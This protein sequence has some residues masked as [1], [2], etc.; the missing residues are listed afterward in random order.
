MFWFVYRNF[1]D[2]RWLFYDWDEKNLRYCYD[3][4]EAKVRWDA[5]GKYQTSVVM[6]RPPNKEVVIKFPLAPDEKR[7]PAMVVH[8]WIRNTKM[9]T[10]LQTVLNQ[11]LD[12]YEISDEGV[13]R[14]REINED[15]TLSNMSRLQ[16]IRDVMEGIFRVNPVKVRASEDKNTGKV[17]YTERSDMINSI[18]DMSYY[19][20]WTEHKTNLYWVYTPAVREAIFPESNFNGHTLQWRQRDAMLNRGK[21]TCIV[22]PRAAGKSMLLT[23]FAGWYAMKDMITK[24]ERNRPFIIHYFGLSKEANN[25]V[26]AYI[27][28][29]MK[30]LIQ[31]DKVVN[32]QKSYN[33][34]TFYDGKHERVIQFKSQYE[35]GVGRGERPN[36]VILD[37]AARLSNEVYKT[38]IGTDEAAIYC[39]STIDYETK[40]NWF[41]DLFLECQKRQR[42]YIPIDQCIHK[43]W[44]KYDM[45]KVRTEEEFRNKV[46]EGVIDAMREDLFLERPMVGL[47]Y[48]IDDIETKTDRQKEEII[49]RAMQQGE[50]Y[51]LAEYYGEYAD[52][53]VE[54]NYEGLLENIMPKIYD[55]VVVWFDNGGIYDR[56]AIVAIGI[57]DWMAYIFASKQ[58]DNDKIKR[59]EQIKEEL[60]NFSRFSREKRVHLVADVSGNHDGAIQYLEEKIGYLDLGIYYTGWESAKKKGPI[61]HVV[62]KKHLVNL[63]KTEFFRKANVLISA[64][65][66]YDGWLLDELSRFKLKENKKYEAV[67]GKDDQVNAM[68]MALYYAYTERLQYEFMDTEKKV[69]FDRD[70]IVRNYYGDIEESKREKE[71]EQ[72]FATIYQDYRA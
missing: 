33:R 53:W 30:K 8:D 10:K 15:V 63:T 45:D 21:I 7:I 47:R 35:E 22:A 60:E 17:K 41:Y 58:V 55:H 42:E 51:V 46:E 56:P 24:E 25:Q 28:M 31:H 64:E 50:D 26:A 12:L 59:Y 43:I 70:T 14:P 23:L 3:P 20:Q 72:A 1:Y 48:T 40:K 61:E 44:T 36:L 49:R 11:F 4:S 13:F 32:W 27:K 71:V 57:V 6:K 52:Q 16:N 19:V 67:T 39:I 66:G 54:F 65:L 69:T 62:G 18:E 2:H 9:E 37:E 68:M 29:M 5:F 38:A 34:L